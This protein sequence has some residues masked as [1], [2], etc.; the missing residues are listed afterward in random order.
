MQARTNCGFQARTCAPVIKGKHSTF[1]AAAHEKVG[2]SAF[3]RNEVAGS[4][5]SLASHFAK[6]CPV[7][8]HGWKRRRVEQIEM[9]RPAEGAQV[10]NH[11]AC[12]RQRNRPRGTIGSTLEKSDRPGRLQPGASEYL[13]G[14]S[15]IRPWPSFGISFGE[16]V[17]ESKQISSAAGRTVRRKVEHSTA[18]A[19]KLGSA[20]E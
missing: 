9:F 13:A 17:V 19:K 4:W 3:T 14:P 16:T 12:P 10:P 2:K 6:A 5:F 15:A 20:G 18:A 1:I 8:C 7:L 11:L